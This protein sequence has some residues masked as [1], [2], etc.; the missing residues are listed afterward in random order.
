[1]DLPGASQ[2]G[3]GAAL[4]RVR[5]RY[6]KHPEAFCLALPPLHIDDSTPHSSQ[7]VHSHLQD[8]VEAVDAWA[9]QHQLTVSHQGRSSVL[10]IR[11]QAALLQPGAGS[12]LLAPT[13]T[14]AQLAKNFERHLRLLIDG[15]LKFLWTE[16]QQ[17]C[18]LLSHNGRGARR[19]LKNGHLS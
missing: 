15:L 11:G 2:A 5:S 16:H 7:Q 10:G 17:F 3:T 19:I 13:E 8:A 1:M 12:T 14:R 9:R 4:R 6:R 18:L